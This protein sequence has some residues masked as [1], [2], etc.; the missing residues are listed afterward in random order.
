MSLEKQSS[1]KP[2]SGGAE[3]RTYQN[4]EKQTFKETTLWRA[5][6]QDPTKSGKAKAQE[7]QIPSETLAIHPP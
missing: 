6:N 7:K 3:I 1:D 5:L 2:F 4:P